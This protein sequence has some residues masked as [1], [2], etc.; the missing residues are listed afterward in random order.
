MSST[1]SVS[2]DTFI[3]LIFKTDFRIEQYT[4]YIYR[5]TKYKRTA[6]FEIIT[7]QSPI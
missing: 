3:V 7:K 2:P 6:K 1:V 4:Y 5:Y